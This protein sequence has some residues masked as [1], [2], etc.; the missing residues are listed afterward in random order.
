M[1][2]FCPLVFGLV[3]MHFIVGIRMHN[4]G[5]CCGQN[6]LLFS[7]AVSVSE[8]ALK[9]WS[10]YYL[11]KTN[12]KRKLF[13]S[14][15]YIFPSALSRSLPNGEFSPPTTGH[16]PQSS[17][18][19]PQQPNN[20]SSKRIFTSQWKKSQTKPEKK[21]FQTQEANHWGFGRQR[22]QTRWSMR[23]ASVFSF[24]HSTNFHRV[25]LHADYWSHLLWHNCRTN[26]MRQ[27][28]SAPMRFSSDLHQHSLAS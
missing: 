4:F 28:S 9:G 22:R 21:Y 14:N 11:L 13:C 24:W 5:W 2:P 23:R 17:Q 3:Q 27:I 6:F 8:Q 25:I 26:T 10:N 20:T 15:F 1:C 16:L 7:E 12:W 19:R 18:V